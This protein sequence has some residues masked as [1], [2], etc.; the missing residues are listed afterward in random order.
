MCAE[1]GQPFEYKVIG[2]FPGEK[3]DEIL[4]TEEEMPRAEDCGDYLTI[5]PWWDDRHFDDFKT[6]FSSAEMVVNEFD[7]VKEL[8]ENADE[9][10]SI[11]HVEKGEFSKI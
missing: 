9:K 5:H 7:Q 4:I 10:A 11:V 3:V 6:E 1:A 2:K 8:I